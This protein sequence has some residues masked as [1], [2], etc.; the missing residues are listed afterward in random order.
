MT[1]TERFWFQEQTRPTLKIKIIAGLFS[2][3]YF[4]F[5]PSL[6]AI[7]YSKERR[8]KIYRKRLKHFR[9]SISYNF[10]GR[11]VTWTARNKPLSDKMLDELLK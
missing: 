5:R 3:C 7:T 9:P 11:K 2:V 1:D 6:L 4:I 10:W 8:E